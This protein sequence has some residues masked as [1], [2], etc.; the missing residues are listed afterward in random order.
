MR[1]TDIQ[2]ALDPSELTAYRQFQR[3][4]VLELETDEG[5]ELI[6]ASNAAVLSGKLRQWT[7]GA[8]Y[9]EDGQSYRETNTAKLERLKEMMEEIHTP[10]IIVYEFRHELERLRTTFP[11]ARTIDEPGV[12]DA[13]NRGEVP[14]LLG[15]PASMGHGLNLQSGGHI[16][17]WYTLTWSLELY[18]QMNARLARQGQRERV[19]I[20]HMVATGTLDERVVK[21][22]QSKEQG[23]DA[24]M[25]A[26]KAEIRTGAK[27]KTPNV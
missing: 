16:I 12:F 8:L 15:H 13:W 27:V 20:Y 22:L 23:Q 5:R 14:I 7:G 2:V 10:V 3:E 4:Q 26:I 24:L 21:A 25:E 9:T 17:I 19:T 11:K 1:Y 6:T 18:Q